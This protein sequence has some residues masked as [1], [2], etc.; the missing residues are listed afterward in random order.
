ML[1]GFNARTDKLNVFDNI[2][3]NKMF[4][5]IMGLIVAIQVLMTFIGG[6]ILRTAPLTLKEWSVVI[7]LSLIVLPVGAIRKLIFPAKAE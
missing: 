3:G 7:L 5:Y 6:S 1:N 4:L 2:S